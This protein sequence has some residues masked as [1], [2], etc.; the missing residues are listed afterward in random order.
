MDD[1]VKLQRT[2][3]N[4]CGR[5]IRA[6]AMHYCSHNCRNGHYRTRVI[7]LWLDGALP[8]RATMLSV[9]RAH[10]IET[11]GRQ[12]QRCGWGVRNPYS[13]RLPL[14]IEH[15]DGDWSN[16]APNN[17]IVLCPNCHALT[18]TFKGANRGKGRP[19]RGKVLDSASH[20]RRL[21]LSELERDGTRRWSG[22]L[23]ST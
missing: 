10:L 2:C 15:V 12:C 13:G 18:R 11:A 4:G 14:E 20:G 16:D 8:P 19:F 22:E 6:N 7:A 21:R 3:A 5:A 1:I 9:L 17:L 23:P